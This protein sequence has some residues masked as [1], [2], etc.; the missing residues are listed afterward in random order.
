MIYDRFTTDLWRFYDY[1]MTHRNILC[2]SGPWRRRRNW[3]LNLKLGTRDYVVDVTHNATIRSNRSSGELAPNR[4]NITLLW[5]FV[6]LSFFF[7]VTRPAG[8]V[9]PILTLNGSNDVFPPKDGPFGGQDDG[10][11]HAGKYA[12][13]TSQ[14]GAWIGSFKPKRQNTSQYLRN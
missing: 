13:K 2:K 14:K 7:S 12:V 1:H 10:Y 9:A 3:N 4:E 5:L 8:T 11:R 6:V